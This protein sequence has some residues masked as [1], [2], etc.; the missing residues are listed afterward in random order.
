MF[1]VILE[2]ARGDQLKFGT[3]TPF[4][5]VEI[6]GLNP[7]PATINVSEMALVDGVRFNSS[8]LQGKTLNVAFAIEYEAAKNRIEVYKVLKTK[9]WVRFYFKNQYRDVYID[10]YVETV[11]ISFFE[12]K[13]IVTVA[14]IC[15]SPYFTARQTSCIEGVTI[16]DTFTFPFS[17]TATP[18]LTFG[19]VSANAVANIKNDGDVSCGMIITIDCIND[20]SLPKI[21]NTATGDFIMV[22][23]QM[24]TGD[25]LVID[26]RRGKKTAM[27][28]HEGVTTNVFQN[29]VEGSTWLQL[30][31]QNNV[32][33]YE[34]AM[35]TESD[36]IVSFEFN[37]L[38]E[39]V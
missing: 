29:I 25:T 14:I 15:P 28:T 26:T 16:S 6:Q 37:A 4:S 32:F 17:S 22:Q 21:I 5:I 18:Q 35:G 38:Y 31:P 33:T 7:T 36:I 1:D 11:D 39:G 8:K 2:N 20:I 12:M 34:V 30:E 23:V 24:I 3:G 19:E 13:Q 10:G 27:M 9:Q